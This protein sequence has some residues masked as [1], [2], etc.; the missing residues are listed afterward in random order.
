VD[1]L[2]ATIAQRPDLA[3]LL[4]DFNVWPMF[5][6]QDPI[7]SLY[8]ADP[9]GMYP[10][11]VIVAVDRDEPGRLV[12][13]GFCVPFSWD[14]DP[15]ET[16]PEDGWDGVIIQATLDRLAGR[17]GNIVSAL[18]IS[19]RPDLR[20]AGVSAVMLEA[21]RANARSLGFSSLVAPVRANGKHLHPDMS[22]VDYAALRRDDGL[23][24]DPWL[25]VH[26]RAGGTVVGVAARAMA[27]AGSLDEWR[28]WTGLPFDTTG[29]VAV[30]EALVPVLCDVEQ[31]YASYTEPGI[32]VHHGLD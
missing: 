19:V 9:V 5:M 6:R 22:I 18:E 25:R 1:L 15:S 2:T 31:G 21:M 24:V 4:G 11:Y 26:V 16:L 14:E 17:R 12:A 27:I 7:G 20:G 32:W 13:K 28:D 29:P 10:E 23:P 30:P 3:P 8:Y